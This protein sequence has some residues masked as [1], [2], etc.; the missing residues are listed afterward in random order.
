MSR[1][2]ICFLLS[3]PHINNSKTET[4]LS[5]IFLLE[6]YKVLLAPHT[7]FHIRKFQMVLSETLRSKKCGTEL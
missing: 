2:V 5:G 6:K 3:A 1:I 4:V 7:Y